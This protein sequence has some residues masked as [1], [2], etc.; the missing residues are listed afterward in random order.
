MQLSSVRDGLGVLLPIRAKGSSHP[1][2][3]IHPAGGLSWCYMPLAQYAPADIPLYGLQ[4]PSLDH[5]GEFPGSV[6]EMAAIYVE[7]IRS[8][9]PAGPYHLLGM[10]FGGVPAHEIAVQLRAAGEDVA[11]LVF[12]DAYPAD[13]QRAGGPAPGDQPAGETSDESQEAMDPDAGLSKVVAWMRQEAGQ[14]LGA[15]SDDEYLHLAQIYRKNALIKRSHQHGR[16]DGDALLVV[17]TES[18]TADTPTGQR[19]R[20]FVTGEITEVPIPCTHTDLARAEMLG[21]AWA[22]I[23]DWLGLEA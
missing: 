6:R 3:C 21:R 18:R 8:V 5:Q 1:F 14:V 23:S 12:L 16:F 11:A 13:S 22:A 10:S 2:F 20:P 19:W 15:I 17:A 4:A 9:Q 7:R